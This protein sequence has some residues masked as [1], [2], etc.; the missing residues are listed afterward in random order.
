MKLF[1]YI[2]P[3]FFLLLTT[4][5]L[6]AQEVILSNLSR[7]IVFSCKDTNDFLLLRRPL[8]TLSLITKDNNKIIFR[9][10]SFVYDADGLFVETPSPLMIIQKTDTMRIYGLS[11]N[12]HNYHLKNFE[13]K[14]GN[15]FIK[16]KP[17]F[18][19]KVVTGKEIMHPD[20]EICKEHRRSPLDAQI[21]QEP[22]YKT[23]PFDEM[24]FF[25]IDLADINEGEMISMDSSFSN[26]YY[27]TP[28]SDYD[29]LDWQDYL[30]FDEDAKKYVKK[31]RKEYDYC[32][33]GLRVPYI[34]PYYTKEEYEES[35]K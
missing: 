5:S 8:D 1:R 31:I 15:W 7:L 29:I 20:V 21:S 24:L 23:E 6:L 16:T 19:Q 26:K 9:D 30:L 18:Q 17:W 35:I 11:S 12:F 2:V 27:N 10:F 13:F 25:E 3:I 34:A 32:G 22:E 33:S 4:I 14:K 28:R